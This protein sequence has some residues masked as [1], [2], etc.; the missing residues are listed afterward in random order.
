MK[1]YVLIGASLL[2]LAVVGAGCAAPDE[3]HP[4]GN[5]PEDAQAAERTEI[6]AEMIADVTLDSEPQLL[7]QACKGDALLGRDEGIRLFKV[8]YDEFRVDGAPSAAEVYDEIMTR[9]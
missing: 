7:K 5:T 6:S 4:T 3:N 8:G 9:C 2:G 1:K